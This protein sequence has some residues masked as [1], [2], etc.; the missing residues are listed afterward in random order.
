VLK[1][2]QRRQQIEELVTERNELNTSKLKLESELL[3]HKILLQSKEAELQRY[4]EDGNQQAKY[5]V[6]TVERELLAKDE[7]IRQMSE[8]VEYSRQAIVC[9]LLV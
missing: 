7:V 9:Y 1:L 3:N 4:R 6:E 2:Q 8:R 5:K